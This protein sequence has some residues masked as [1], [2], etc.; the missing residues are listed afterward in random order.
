MLLCVSL[1]VVVFLYVDCIVFQSNY[2]RTAVETHSEA[3]EVDFQSV[4]GTCPV[5]KFLSPIP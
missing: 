5:S 3:D 2:H 1:V 4:K